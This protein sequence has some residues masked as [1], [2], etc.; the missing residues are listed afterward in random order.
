MRKVN[1]DF[2]SFMLKK[3]VNEHDDEFV[4][5]GNPFSTKKSRSRKDVNPSLS[6]SALSE[7]IFA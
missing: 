5:Q 2:S 1:A 3:I 6:F 4:D 7:G